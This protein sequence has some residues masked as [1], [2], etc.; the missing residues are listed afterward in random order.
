ML[1]QNWWVWSSEKRW[2]TRF[3]S[4]WTRVFVNCGRQVWKCRYVWLSINYDDGWISNLT[5]GST[6][7]LFESRSRVV[8]STVFLYNI[9]SPNYVL[10]NSIITAYIFC[11]CWNVSCYI[12]L[13]ITSLACSSTFISRSSFIWVDTFWD[14]SWNK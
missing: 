1:L 10:D 9:F 4:T 3:Y 11:I 2:W 6:N 12:L 5:C 14:W 8:G 7:I 13:I